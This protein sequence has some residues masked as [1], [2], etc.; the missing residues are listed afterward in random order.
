MGEP[1]ETPYF[2]AAIIGAP[3]LQDNAAPASSLCRSPIIPIHL[4]ETTV[5]L[6]SGDC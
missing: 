4:Y 3:P 2:A 5:E 6:F 1:C